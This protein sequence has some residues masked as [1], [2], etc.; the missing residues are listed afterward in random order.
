MTLKNLGSDCNLVAIVH[1]LERVLE[2]VVV[3]S[4]R[5]HVQRWV[6]PLVSVRL[7][8]V[9]FQKPFQC[10]VETNGNI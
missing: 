9:L 4:C 8:E 5:A 2:L 1:V 3:G 7:L 10:I 6:R